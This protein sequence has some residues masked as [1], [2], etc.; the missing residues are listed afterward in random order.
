M[1]EGVGD[2]ELS[3]AGAVT[4]YSKDF[5]WSKGAEVLPYA[6]PELP[7]GWVWDA[8]CS[9]PSDVGW[10]RGSVKNLE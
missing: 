5:L 8:H 6:A 9:L 3:R 7:L 1:G 4:E 10:G 2:L